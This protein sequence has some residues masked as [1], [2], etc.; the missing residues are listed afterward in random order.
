MLPIGS[1]FFP[2]IVAPFKS[3]FFYVETYSTF[4]KLVF[5]Y[6]D[7]NILRV[8]VHLLLIVQL[9]SK[10]FRSLKFWRKKITIH[11]V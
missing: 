11:A 8:R 9:N 2:L 7:T 4:Q 5:D 6:T 1:I 3:G 10:V